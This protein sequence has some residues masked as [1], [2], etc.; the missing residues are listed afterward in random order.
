MGYNEAAAT[1]SR[2]SCYELES[3]SVAAF[4]HAI[5]GGQ[6]T[7][8]ESILLGSYPGGE[9]R[10]EAASDLIFDGPVGLRLAEGADKNHMLF[11]MRQQKFLEYLDQRDL[12]KALTVL[13]QE[14]TPLNHDIHQLHALSRYTLQ[15]RTVRE[16]DDANLW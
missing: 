13:R 5:M 10:V 4:R 3:P 6:W 16:L 7:E 8:A 11:S 9:E 1:L 2:E 12:S 14:L 15:R